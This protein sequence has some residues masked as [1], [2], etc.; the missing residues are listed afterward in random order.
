MPSLNGSNG[1][2]MKALKP[3]HHHHHMSGAYKPSVI[4]IS[5]VSYRAVSLT[6]VV[7]KMLPVRLNRVICSVY[8]HRLFYLFSFFSRGWF[9]RRE[10]QCRPNAHWA[11]THTHTHHQGFNGFVDEKDG[12][13]CRKHFPFLFVYL[14]HCF[15]P[16]L[17]WI[18]SF[19][20]MC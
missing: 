2:Y 12:M 18:E 3:F 7:V 19:K 17:F 4:L 14:R 6:T 11:L 8:S 15:Q 16:W 5:M 10:L 20:I 1:V 9:N 13:F